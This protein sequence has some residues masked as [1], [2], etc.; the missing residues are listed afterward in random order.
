MFIVYCESEIYPEN[1]SFYK[2]VLS[3]FVL[4]TKIRTVLIIQNSP[5]TVLQMGN[6]ECS[7][8]YNLLDLNPANR[9]KS[10]I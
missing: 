5:S 8:V 10:A 3:F 1:V 6:F 9:G 2:S 7:T 4:G